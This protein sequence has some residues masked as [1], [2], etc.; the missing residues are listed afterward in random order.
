MKNNP[1]KKGDICDKC[2]GKL[3]QRDDDRIET[4]KNRMSVYHAQTEPIKDYY[5]KLGK[6]VCVD[7]EGDVEQV[8]KALF[9]ALS[10]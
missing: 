1:S 8:R 7:G 6:L 2:G 5:K 3:I 10:L 9:K 4:I